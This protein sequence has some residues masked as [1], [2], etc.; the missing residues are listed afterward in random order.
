M[1]AGSRQICGAYAV[2]PSAVLAAHRAQVAAPALSSWVGEETPRAVVFLDF[3]RFVTDSDFFMEFRSDL[4]FA[5][6]YTTDSVAW[7]SD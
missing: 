2:V 3:L 6:A 5:C 1:R 4:C 7:A